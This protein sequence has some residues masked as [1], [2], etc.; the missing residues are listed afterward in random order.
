[1]NSF[2][3]GARI[4]PRGLL[5]RSGGVPNLFSIRHPMPADGDAAASSSGAGVVRAATA[6]LEGAKRGRGEER[7]T[8]RSDDS[9]LNELLGQLQSN[10]SE[11]M[12]ASIDKS[13]NELKDSLRA[14]VFED[15]AALIRKRGE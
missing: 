14:S 3:N 4:K 13:V 2:K 10:L 11:T 1:M 15:T 6:A 9:E 12:E 5:V 8:G 7:K